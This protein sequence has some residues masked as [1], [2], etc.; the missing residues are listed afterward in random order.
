MAGAGHL[1]TTHQQK[2]ESEEE[3]ESEARER[4]LGSRRGDG[5]DIGV[6]LGV[7]ATR[8]PLCI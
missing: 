5:S 2:R 8:R 6:Q 7:W 3:G 4:H 1:A